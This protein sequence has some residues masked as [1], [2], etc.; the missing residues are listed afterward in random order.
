MNPYIDM[1][2]YQ[3]IQQQAQQHHISQVIEVQKCA[4]ALHDFLK[5][6]IRLNPTI[7]KQQVRSSAQFCLITSENTVNSI[8]NER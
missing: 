2:N 5:A 4:K 6:L 1:F 3:Y 7:S 8:P